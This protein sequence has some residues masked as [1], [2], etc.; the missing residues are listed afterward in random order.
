MSAIQVHSIYIYSVFKKWFQST[1]IT[2]P[3]GK[4]EHAKIPGWLRRFFGFYLVECLS[5]SYIF[6]YKRIYFY[7]CIWSTHK[8]IRHSDY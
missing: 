7:M 5:L 1:K 8:I 3:Y 4:Y 6:F 2:I